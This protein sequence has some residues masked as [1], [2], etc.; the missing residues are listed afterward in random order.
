M[1]RDT[2]M[3]MMFLT[4]ESEADLVWTHLPPAV[5]GPGAEECGLLPSLQTG[6]NSQLVIRGYVRV[7]IKKMSC[8]IKSS[9][10]AK[11]E[12]FAGY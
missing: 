9:K 2:L 10:M 6:N 11:S 3:M 12:M 8:V 5:P 7:L 1:T 4:Q